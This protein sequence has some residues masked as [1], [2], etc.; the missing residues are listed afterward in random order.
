MKKRILLGMS[1]G[2]DSSVSA[3]LLKRRGYDVIGITMQLLPKE[4]E[5]QSACCNLDAVCDAQRV[6]AK[7]EIPHFVV[8]IRDTF[9]DKV[10]NYFVDQYVNGLTPNPCIECNRHIKFDE[11]RKIGLEMGTDYV[12]TG[13]YVRRLFSPAT[14]RF[15]L[16]KA[17]DLTKDQSYFL[18]MLSS[19][20]LAKTVFPLGDFHKTDVRKMAE[21]MGLINAQKPDSQEICFVTKGTYKQFV[22]DQLGERRIEGGAI[23]N[24]E[25]TVLGFHQ[26]I[27]QFTIGQRKG[28]GIASSEP[29][30]VI[31]INPSDRSVTVGPKGALSSSRIHLHSTCLVDDRESIVGRTLSM[32]MRY[33]MT[34]FQVEVES[35][36]A[37]EAIIRCVIPQEFT[38][39]GQSAVIYDGNRVVGGGVIR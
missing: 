5:K 1:G 38:S 14:R 36:D 23:V 19:E 11:L 7:L 6:A 30:Y 20:Q 31:K 10:I 17:K 9:Q 22:H 33:Q 4:Q 18:Y 25:G 16:R 12:A 21:T 27:H 15:T 37:T 13:H 39:P 3:A 26:G 24:L 34:P 2:V 32:K 28:L 35:W 29:L 8:N